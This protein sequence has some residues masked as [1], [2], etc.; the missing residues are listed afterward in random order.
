MDTA[1]SML[2]T[3]GH[4][5]PAAGTVPSVQGTCYPW[6][7]KTEEWCPKDGLCLSSLGM[8]SQNLTSECFACLRKDQIN[9]NH[10]AARQN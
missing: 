10:T 4:G 7:G 5:C 1:L 8:N 3:A 2:T 9:D 6:K